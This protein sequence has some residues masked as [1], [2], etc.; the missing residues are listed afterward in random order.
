MAVN[1]QFLA[2]TAS[3]DQS[4]IAPF[5]NS[6]KVYVQGSRPDLRV[7]FRKITQDDTPSQMGAEKNPPIYVYDTSGPYTDP[8]AKIIF[9]QVL[10]PFAPNGSMS[11]T[12]PSASLGPPAPL[13]RIDSMILSL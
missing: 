10:L 9:A 7:P 8:Q 12:T 13:A 4:A 3:V 5:P 6:E 11:V 2:A 1:P